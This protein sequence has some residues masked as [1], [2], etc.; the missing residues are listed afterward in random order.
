MDSPPISLSYVIVYFVDSQQLTR[1]QRL[2]H[3]FQ[4]YKIQVTAREDTFLTTIQHLQ[5]SLNKAE[6]RIT[7]LEHENKQYHS[8]N[9]N[10]QLDSNSYQNHFSNNF[11]KS[12][13]QNL[14]TNSNQYSHSN[15]KAIEEPQEQSD[16]GGI[17]QMEQT[18]DKMETDT[19]MDQGQ[20]SIEIVQNQLGK[21]TK[22]ENILLL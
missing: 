10:H 16:Y 21:N 1:Q 19:L 20:N 8:Q 22:S 3:D 13:I 6:N 9:I 18:K 12:N 2:V 11:K 17:I 7:S 15:I 4:E 5:T 14:K